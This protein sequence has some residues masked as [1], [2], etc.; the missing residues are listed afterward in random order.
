M[1]PSMKGTGR[2]TWQMAREDSSIPTETCMKESGL[3]TRH[4]VEEHISTWMELST[5]EIGEKISNTDTVLKHG[6]MV[7]SMKATTN[8]E[9]STELEHSNGLM[10]HS[11]LE[12]STIIIY[13]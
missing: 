8:T 3:T 5:G 11:T 6:Q 13:M 2:M 4:M 12:N 7:Q 9:R 10:D 1:G